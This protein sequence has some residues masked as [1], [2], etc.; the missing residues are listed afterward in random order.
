M[1]C[2]WWWWGWDNGHDMSCSQKKIQLKF[3][4]KCKKMFFSIHIDFF[5][6]FDH[7]YKQTL[8][9]LIFRLYLRLKQ[10]NFL[11]LVF[12][13]LFC[14]TPFESTIFKP[15]WSWSIDLS[16]ASLLSLKR[17]FLMN[18][19]GKQKLFD[20]YDQSSKPN[21]FNPLLVLVSSGQIVFVSVCFILNEILDFCF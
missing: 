9:C 5:Q 21:L 14:S 10:C 8:K 3:S 13:E 15:F 11:K 7:Y 20:C 4:G 18:P 6:F 16:F 1:E 19:F 2:V 12:F 17:D